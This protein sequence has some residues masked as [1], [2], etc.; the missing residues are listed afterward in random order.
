MPIYD[1]L[2][3]KCEH[4]FDHHFQTFSEAEKFESK[5]KCPKCKSVKKEKLISDS[6]FQLKGKGWAKDRYGK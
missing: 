2:C 3:T 1:Y 6:S 4:K 5:L